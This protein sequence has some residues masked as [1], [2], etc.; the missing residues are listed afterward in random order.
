MKKHK[1]K[2]FSLVHTQ[3]T[4]IA[5]KS[6][7]HNT[8]RNSQFLQN[9]GIFSSIHLPFRCQVSVKRFN[10]DPFFGPKFLVG[11]ARL[12]EFFFSELCAATHFLIMKVRP[13]P[14]QNN[15]SFHFGQLGACKIKWFEGNYSPLDFIFSLIG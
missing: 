15:G 4:K 13:K 3:L 8:N 2:I 11:N 9:W 7:Q 6:I 14:F 5:V 12:W 10:N 1:N